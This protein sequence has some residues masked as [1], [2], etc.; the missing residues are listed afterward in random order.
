MMV[1]EVNDVDS[2][3]ESEVQ[4]NIHDESGLKR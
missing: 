1:A 2:D 4:D 3:D